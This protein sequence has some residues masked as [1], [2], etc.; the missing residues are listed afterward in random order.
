M[1]ETKQLRYFIAVAESSSFSNA[2]QKLYITQPA[3]SQQI[4]K[5]EEQLGV[6]LVDRNTRFV[7]LTAAGRDLYRRSLHLLRELENMVQSVVSADSLGFT[8]Q[9]LTVCLEDGM[10]FLA[11]TGAFEFL[12]SLRHFDPAFTVECVPS[13]A[14]SIPRLL[15][16]GTV[17]LAIAFSA[18]DTI[19]APN[20]GE[21]CFHRGRLALAVPNDWNFSFDSPEFSRSASAS[22]FYLPYN[23]SYWHGAVNSALAKYN[24]HPRY[25]SIENFE[26]AL[27][28]VAA[29]AG[30]FFAPEVQLRAMNS[31]FFHIIPI[32]DPLAEYRVS[33]LY[34][35]FNQSLVLQQLLDLLPAS[36]PA[37][38]VG[39]PNSDTLSVDPL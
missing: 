35:V 23:R 36:P 17:D 22:V 3:L 19:L 1:I 27:N 39:T 11:S 12:D 25:V 28:Y 37:L 4:S 38:S 32:P 16:E 20:I 14:G 13:I 7:Q 2:A 15:L 9:T 6:I 21:R 18:S 5:L 33:V 34:S 30:M 8:S 24:F 31:P 29:G 26:S 10:F